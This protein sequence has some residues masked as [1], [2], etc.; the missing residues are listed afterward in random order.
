MHRQKQIAS[1][2]AE[3]KLE[4][5]GPSERK[6]AKGQN[7]FHDLLIRGLR[8]MYWSEKHLLKSSVKLKQAAFT[9]HLQSALQDLFQKS[10]EHIQNLVRVFEL[11]GEKPS[12]KKCEG[13]QGLT[14]EAISMSREINKRTH[15]HDAAQ[16][17]SVQKIK[18]YQ[19]AVYGSL[20]EFA[21]TMG[22]TDVV[23]ILETILN[24]EKEADQKLNE[25]AAGT[26]NELARN[27]WIEELELH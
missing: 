6:M 7:L 21:K 27:E 23:T 8:E 16:I 15:T 10:E 17:M 22:H 11:I 4:S 18:H 26:I 5:Y 25:L 3:G 1:L 9:D 12:G 24:K 2:K 19:I 20:A 13:M 14:D